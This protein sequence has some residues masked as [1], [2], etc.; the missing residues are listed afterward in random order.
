MTTITWR[1]VGQSGCLFCLW[2][3]SNATV[4][5]KLRKLTWF[6][7]DNRC[8]TLVETKYSSG[9]TIISV[10][11]KPRIAF[12]E[13]VLALRWHVHFH[14]LDIPST[15]ISYTIVPQLKCK[16]KCKYQMP[17][18]QI[19]SCVHFWFLRGSITTIKVKCSLFINIQCQSE[20][21]SCNNYDI[22][23]MMRWWFFNIFIQHYTYVLTEKG[24]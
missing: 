8:I 5:V 14:F 1:P 17:L 16:K 7:V 24:H 4:N 11:G 15:T 21:Y 22:L 6:I 13:V 9:L 12:E 3:L 19:S 20:W 23:E 10:F 18:K 2:Q